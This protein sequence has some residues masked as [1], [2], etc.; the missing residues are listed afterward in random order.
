MAVNAAQASVKTVADPNASYESLKPLWN[1]SRAVCSGERFV[2]DYD[3]A[4]DTLRFNNLLIPF[5][6]TMTQQQYDFYKAEAELPG[7]TAQFSKML[8]GGLLRKRPLLT[9]PDD[10]PAEAQDW[11]MNQFGKDDASL[12]AFLDSALW[13]EVQTS[14]AWVFVDYPKVNNPD[15]L[16]KEDLIKYKPYPVLYQAESIINWR[17]RSDKFGKSVLDRVI[18]RGYV[19]DFTE[20]EFHA[21]FKD[22]VW[23]HELN[24]AG[25]Y[26]IRKYVRKDK[27]TNIAVI[28]GQT[29]HNPSVKKVTVELVE[30]I[31]PQANGAPLTIIPAW[32]LNGSIE[33]LEPMLSPIIDK[34]VSLYNKLSRRNHLLY[35]AATYT[36]YIASD[37]PDEDFEEIVDGGLGT[38]IRLRQGDTAGVLET[39]TEALQDM[40]RAIAAAIEEMAKLGIRM[41]TPESSQSGVALEIRNAA[42]TAQLGTLNNKISAVM[43]QVICFMINWKYD[44]SYTPSQIEFS[45]SADFNPIPLG[46][47]WLRLA[48]EWYEKG[49]IPRSVWLFMLKQNDM[50]SPDY[51]DEAG[52][53]EING[54]QLLMPKGSDNFA[55]DLMNQNK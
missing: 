25:N 11:I 47:D 51:D 9:L 38:W 42:Q 50:V 44:K 10:A 31:V 23:V 34:E 19:E 4:V 32:P 8:I 49:L 52:K 28:A 5:S 13:E 6:P 55:N 40:D 45:L 30:T 29:Q 37:M 41:L 33:A 54:D 48:T 18:V 17:I 36:P 7:I 24:E 43:T 3:S 53:T 35:G 16:T 26:Q 2:K 15:E 27:E 12:S 22:A 20:N 14:R 1:K 46:A 39:P 21:S